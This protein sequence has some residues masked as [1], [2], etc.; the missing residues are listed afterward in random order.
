MVQLAGLAGSTPLASADFTP[1]YAVIMADIRAQIA[2]HRLRPGD[3]LPSTTEL[4]A[5]YGHLSPTGRLSAGTVR[6]AVQDLIE[7]GTLRGHQGVGV[8]VAGP[9]PA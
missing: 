8:F 9:P 2:D 6:K 7:D 4:A 3:Q 5:A 1:Y